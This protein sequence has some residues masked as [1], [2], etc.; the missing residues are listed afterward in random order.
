VPL[1][2]HGRWC[3]SPGVRGGEAVAGCVRQAAKQMAGETKGSRR[4]RTDC[5]GTPRNVVTGPDAL[6]TRGHEPKQG[7]WQDG[8]GRSRSPR[9]AV[10]SGPR[11]PTRHRRCWNH[12]QAKGHCRVV[13]AM[14]LRSP[15]S[16]GRYGIALGRLALPRGGVRIGV[17]KPR[18]RRR[19]DRDLVVTS[20]SF[21]TRSLPSAGAEC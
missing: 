2:W 19:T 12:R 13:W 6:P 17:E 15:R 10:L 20:A 3:G 9:R 16:S 11:P 7:R 8:S 4:I 5:T 21:G 1:G 18:H 14:G